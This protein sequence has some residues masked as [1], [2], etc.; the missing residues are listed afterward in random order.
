MDTNQDS[1]DGYYSPDEMTPDKDELSEDLEDI[2]D[3]EE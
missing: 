1:D 3:E 2:L